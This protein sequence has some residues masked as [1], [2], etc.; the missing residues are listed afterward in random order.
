MSVTRGELLETEPLDA[1]GHMAFDEAVLE[2][3]REG[4]TSL[5]FYRWSPEGDPCAVTFG[6]SQA[7]ADAEAAAR[8]KLGGVSVPMVRRA[9]GGGVVF[10]GSDVTFSLV[11]PWPTLSDPS[12]VYKDVHLAVHLGFKAGGVA[13]GL[14]SPTRAPG[15]RPDCFAG[16]EPKDLVS[17]MGN[18]ALGGALRRRRG[19]GL[20]QGSLRPEVL[21]VSPAAARTAVTEGLSVGWKALFERREPPPRAAARAAQLRAERYSTDRWNRRR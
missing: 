11:F 14:W 7:F 15:L 5:R 2:E 9:T 17:P 16:P 12:L 18:K 8:A 4:V 6:F 10:H 21:G 19:R 1:A 3:G 20:Y 13:T